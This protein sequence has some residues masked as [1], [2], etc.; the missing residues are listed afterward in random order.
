MNI[1]WLETSNNQYCRHDHTS[2][3]Q[4]AW[5]QILYIW[6]GLLPIL[7]LR[8]YSQCWMLEL[9]GEWNSDDPHN[10]DREPQNVVWDREERFLK[11]KMNKASCDL[12]RQKRTGV[13]DCRLIVHSLASTVN[14]L[15]SLNN[16]DLT[17]KGNWKKRK[18]FHLTIWLTSSRHKSKPYVL[19]PAISKFEYWSGFRFPVSVAGWTTPQTPTNCLQKDR[20]FLYE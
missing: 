16:Y 11:W 5:N 19:H 12:I 7:T 3:I 18:D 6:V 20:T 17:L 8:I 2:N 14:V 13:K 10:V 1:K 15:K 4:C 9:C